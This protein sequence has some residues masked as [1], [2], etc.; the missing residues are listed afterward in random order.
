M[1]RLVRLTGGCAWLTGAAALA[2]CSPESAH[3]VAAQPTERGEQ[4]YLQNC[5][6]CHQENGRGIPNVYPSLAGSA[7]ALGDPTELAQWVLSQKRPASIPAG[8]YATSMLQF[9]WLKDA[10]AGLLLTY[11][12]RSWG[13]SAP[14]IDAATVAGSRAK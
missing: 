12:R 7:A 3:P 9:G 6:P 10:D 5:A 4:M 14:P 13:N 1:A 11:I 2:A 8:R